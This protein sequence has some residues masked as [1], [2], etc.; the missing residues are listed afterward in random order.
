MK[1]RRRR[2]VTLLGIKRPTFDSTAREIAVV[3]L[4]VFAYCL[5]YIHGHG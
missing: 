2:M 4:V 5:Y 1:S 3:C